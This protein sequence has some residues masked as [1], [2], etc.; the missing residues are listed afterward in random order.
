[1]NL[2]FCPAAS[3]LRPRARSSAICLGVVLRE[4]RSLESAYQPLSPGND[5]LEPDHLVVLLGAMPWVERQ[6][7]CR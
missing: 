7:G 3:A 6:R 4:R 5:G 2:Q 1:M